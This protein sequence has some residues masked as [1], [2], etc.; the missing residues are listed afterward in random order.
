MKKTTKKLLALASAL[1]MA[2]SSTL[3]APLSAGAATG[4]P[5]HVYITAN[6]GNSDAVLTVNYDYAGDESDLTYQWYYSSGNSLRQ[7]GWATLISDATNKTYQL[8]ADAVNK[9]VFCMVTA[10]DGRAM[11]E[12]YGKIVAADA[13]SASA[14]TSTKDAMHIYAENGRVGDTLYAHYTYQNPA[15]TPEGDTEIIWQRSDAYNGKYQDIATGASYTLTPEDYGKFIKYKLRIKDKDGAGSGEVQFGSSEVY[16]TPENLLVGAKG[17]TDSNYANSYK[18]SFRA[19][20]DFMRSRAI[21]VFSGWYANKVYTIDAG[22]D[23]AFDKLMIAWNQGANLPVTKIEVSS[24]NTSY[25]EA[26]SSDGTEDQSTGIFILDNVYTARYIKII[27]D[28]T[29]S[30]ELQIYEIQAFLQPESFSELFETTI[31]GA[32]VNRDGAIITSIPAGTTAADLKAS[33]KTSTAAPTMTVLNA[34][35]EEMAENEAITGGYVLVSTAANGRTVTRYDLSNGDGSEMECS[36]TAVNGEYGVLAGNNIN[37]VLKGTKA[38]DLLSSITVSEGATAEVV[39]NPEYLFG[40]E[41]IKVTAQDHLHS[42][43][44]TLTA[45]QD[46]YNYDFN[47]AKLLSELSETE[48]PNGANRG[49]N[50]YSV[51]SKV[52]PEAGF[53][54][55]YAG[56]TVEE[57]MTGAKLP[58][59]DDRVAQISVVNYQLNSTYSP[60]Y[61]IQLIQDREPDADK[62]YMARFNVE[63]VNGHNAK[64]YLMAG[65]H[66]NGP[67]IGYAELKNSN[68]NT[69]YMYITYNA[70]TQ[71]YTVKNFVNG[72]LTEV[73]TTSADLTKKGFTFGL[74]TWH[75]AG[76]VEAPVNVSARFDNLAL[77]EV[78][79]LADDITVLPEEFDFTTSA[80]GVEI[81]HLNTIVTLPWNSDMTAGE[82]KAKFTVSDDV[83]IAV[84]NADSTAVVDDSA[85]VQ[86]GM[87][88]VFKSGEIWRTYTVD[89]VSYSNGTLT[90]PAAYKTGTVVFA[91]YDA[92]DKLIDVEISDLSAENSSR[93]LSVTTGEG[94]TYKAML[95]ENMTSLKPLGNAK[96]FK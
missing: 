60:K 22:K 14:P 19:A 76:S 8:T 38:Q 54:Q 15:G 72:Q 34:A 31:D 47:N 35:G 57:Y 3:I 93:T 23:I 52:F 81:D 68:W 86:K 37:D 62:A 74:E 77:Y 66:N 4:A 53:S 82:L 78:A 10:P 48:I 13:E 85:T 24:D 59:K 40:G 46:I 89:V 12:T 88:V 92:D 87:K 67:T 7:D 94:Y 69:V 2:L 28:S 25:A 63:S 79:P 58:L 41:Q 49:S 51:C 56:G 75:G 11:S 83:E 44:Y 16:C 90:V 45:K 91:A 43:T 20:S 29:I 1:S 96:I 73:K 95:W 6:G 80:N 71:E 65:N 64:A 84:H 9:Y 42:K 61:R 17:I 32:Q 26:F 30:K 33:V 18:N 50:P 5:E 21:N 70:Q 55:Y 36:I 27:F 39:G